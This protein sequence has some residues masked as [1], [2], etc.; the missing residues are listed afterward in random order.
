MNDEKLNLVA[1]DALAKR[2]LPGRIDTDCAAKLLGFA[3]HDILSLTY[4]YLV[5]SL[6]SRRNGN[7][8]ELIPFGRALE[9]RIEP[10]ID[11]LPG[12]AGDE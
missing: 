8:S 10:D 7:I 12:I 5:Y 9:C 2:N 11:L 4:F 1:I 6:F 3:G